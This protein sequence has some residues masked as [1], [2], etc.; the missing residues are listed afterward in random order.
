M[1]LGVPVLGERQ[2]PDSPAQ[3]A[4][5]PE[6]PLSAHRALPT[7]SLLLCAQP[8]WQ[9]QLC[10]HGRPDFRTSDWAGRTL[11]RR[12]W[13]TPEFKKRAKEAATQLPAVSPPG[14]AAGGGQCAGWS[15]GSGARSARAGALVPAGRPVGGP[16]GRTHPSASACSDRSGLRD[17]HH[18]GCGFTIVP[19]G[20]SPGQL[21]VRT[22]AAPNTQT[23]PCADLLPL[24]TPLPR[25]APLGTAGDL[26]T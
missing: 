3:V 15:P 10:S 22:G 4:R 14:E 13:R 26:S 2:P 24:P 25:P 23:A 6:L 18:R 9:P 7:G 8:S 21:V 5:P 17:P 12:K 19:F 11:G 20:S 16:A 1:A